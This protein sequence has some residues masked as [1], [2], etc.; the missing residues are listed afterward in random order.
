MLRPTSVALLLVL[1]PA[2]LHAQAPAPP[3]PAGAHATLRAIGSAASVER[4]AADLATVVG[5]GTRHTLSDTLS[6]TRGIGAA[7]RWVHAEL[8]RIS[9][10]CDGC[11]DVEYHTTVVPPGRRMPDS[12]AVVN[13]LGIQRGTRDPDRYIIVSG[14]LDSRASDAMDAESDAPGAV[15]DA[16]GVAAVLEAARLLSRHRFDATIVY[17]AVSGE[18]QGLYG[19]DALARR[20]QEEGWFVE[21]M[22]TND[23]VGNVQGIDGIVDSTT[24]RVFSEGV[25]AD[26]TERMA[27]VRRSTGGEVDSPARQLARYIHR[28]AAEHVPA[29]DVMMIY[30]L[31][32]FGR[33]GDHSPFS[34][35]GFPAVRFTEPHE[36]YRRQHQDVRIED[37]VE[38]GDVL[39]EAEPSY[40][41]RVAGLNAAVIAAM[42]SAPRPPSQVEIEGAVRPSTTLRWQAAD[43]ALAPD[44]AGYRV[45]WRETT[46]P[47]WQHSAWVGA[48][49]EHTIENVVIDNWYF[50]VAAVDRDGYESPVVFAGPIGEWTPQA[51]E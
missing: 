47:V 27:R 6:D 8:S 38:Y 42:A 17:A 49:T 20:A 3:D 1:A 22:F 16:S 29:I 46:A 5:F 50:G 18:E 15:D 39:E 43:S 19:S 37:G 4:V 44:L 7:R 30:R 32:R 13:V 25:R 26:E 40:T 36:D 24:V 51:A 23:V 10:A 11:I 48:V 34:A 31:D 35:R 45:Y 2:A 33:G 14:H 9:A 12:V 28:I 41:A 21:A